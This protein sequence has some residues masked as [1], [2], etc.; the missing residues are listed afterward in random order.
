MTYFD[1]YKTWVYYIAIILAA[2]VCVNAASVYFGEIGVLAYVLNALLY[3][4]FALIFLVLTGSRRKSLLWLLWTGFAIGEFNVEF[5]TFRSMP[6]TPADILAA[7]TGISVFKSYG[8]KIVPEMLM[9]AIMIGPLIAAAIKLIPKE[10]LQIKHRA[11]CLAGS[12]AA[13]AA[14]TAIIPFMPVYEHTYDKTYQNCKDGAVVSFI[15]DLKYMRHPVPE[16]YSKEEAESVLAQYKQSEDTVKTADKPDIVVIMD[17]AFSDLSVLHSSKTPAHSYIPYVKSVLEG[18]VT[19]TQS[20]YLDVSVLGGGTVNTEYEFLTGNSMHNIPSFTMPYQQDITDKTDLGYALPAQAED[21]G[22]STVSIHP[23]D[24]SGYRRN[25][26]YK[27]FGFDKSIFQDDMKHTEKVRDYISDKAVFEEIEDQLN[28]TQKQPKFVFAVTI[29]NHAYYQDT[30]HT[31]MYAEKFSLSDPT[32]FY[33]GK[34][35]AALNTYMTLENI[36]DDAL[37]NFIKWCDNRKKKTIIVFFGDH[38]PPDAVTKILTNDST[39]ASD[40][41][42]VPFII[43][44][45]YK[46]KN[47]TDISTSPNFLNIKLCEDAKIPLNEYQRFRKDIEKTYSSISAYQYRDNI[48][49]TKKW[50]TADTDPTLQMYKKLQYYL[51]FDGAKN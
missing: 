37:K 15:H 31:A 50:E 6:L 8:I 35:T 43:H 13:F 41:F 20:G 17:E 22:Y 14:V 49:I 16:G 2:P 29:Q 32:T 40:Y 42:R 25:Y 4:C 51:M 9:P 30:K 11:A 24:A 46:I 36:T 27:K 7:G 48:G 23:Y 45:N 38:E 12:I 10:R 21:A 44:A 1:K 3:G 28:D 18:D 47:E 26:V 33:S 5:N 34:D 19:N 39:P